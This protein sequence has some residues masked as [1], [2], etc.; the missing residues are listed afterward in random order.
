MSAGRAP[1]AVAAT[2]AS[3]TWV[4]L[5]VLVELAATLG[6]GAPL[7]AQTPGRLSLT[8]LDAVGAP[9]AGARVRLSCA[10]LPRFEQLRNSNDKGRVLLTF[11]D[12][13][14]TYRLGI[15]R[16][17]FQPVELEARTVP[18][19]LE[20]RE[21]RLV[22]VRPAAS[23]GA[24]SDAARAA[25]SAATAATERSAAAAA[26]HNEG[27][28]A[29]RAED[30]GA[31]AVAF[32]RALALDPRLAPA[33][34]GLAV[35][36]LRLGD[37]AAA[38]A[39]A[40]RA[41]ALVPGHARGLAVRYAAARALG[42]E[43]DATDALTAL[44]SADPRAAA[45][46]LVERG[47]ERYDA[48]DVAGSAALAL[49]ALELV[50]DQPRAHYRLA[51]CRLAAGEHGEARRLLLRFLELAPDDPSAAAARD[52]LAGLGGGAGE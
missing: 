22:P 17:G 1:R 49:R 45:E 47:A 15:E 52:L 30:D 51:L 37:P 20:K 43:A 24:E 8:V 23:A 31:A 3:I 32:E 14:N 35:A 4:A 13:T 40:G 10:E 26:A 38:R 21:I 33:H 5:A 28:A 29:L 12:A 42:A 36:R 50:P 18:D 11:P 25:E 27:V 6:L 16:D 2:A 39:A 46:I 34:V 19:E 44:E 7:E 48:G 41:L 9:L